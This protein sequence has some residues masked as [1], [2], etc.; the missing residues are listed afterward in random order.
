MEFKYKLLLT[1]NGYRYFP[2]TIDESF[3]NWNESG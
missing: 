3:N 1:K 2:D